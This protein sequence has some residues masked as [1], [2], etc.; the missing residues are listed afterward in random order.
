MP[1]TL[2]KRV[3]LLIINV[4]QKTLS[5]DHGVLGKMYPNFRSCKFTPTCSEY[6]YTAVERFGVFKGNYL[7]VRRFLRCNPWA[8]TGQFDPVPEK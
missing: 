7:A 6:G 5:L 8:K 2:L 3:E 1:L 4:Y